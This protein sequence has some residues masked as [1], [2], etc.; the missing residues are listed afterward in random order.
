MNV[1]IIGAVRDASPEFKLSLE[2][3]V[4]ELE[5]NGH[6]V[7][8]PHRDTKQDAKGIDICRQNIQAI[9]DAD[10]VHLFYRPDSQ[11]SHFDMGVAFALNKPLKVISCP[12]YGEGKSFPRM[13]HEWQELTKKKQNET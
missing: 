8:L 6:K 11:G 13:V 7:H 5:Q 2:L 1:F 10:E 3:H 12:S 4:K 9:K